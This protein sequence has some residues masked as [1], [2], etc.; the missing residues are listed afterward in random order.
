MST[1]DYYETLR[2][3][4]T[5]SQED[6]AEAYRRLS[7][8]HHPKNNSIANEAT[9]EYTFNQLAEAYEV[10]SDPNKK[11][12]YDIYGKDGLYNGIVDKNNN[13]KG[14]YKYAGNAHQIFEA[15]MGTSNPFALLRDCDKMNDECG[16][17]F[18]SAYGGQYQHKTSSTTLEPVVVELQCSLRELYNGAVKEIEYTKTV[19]NGDGHITSAKTCTVKVE[20][21]PGYGKESVI[22]FKEMGNE[23]PGKRSSDLI[24]KIVEMKDEVFKRVNTNDL[25]YIKRISLADAL[26]SVPVKINT[27]DNR[28]LAI[29]MDEIIT[30][31][32]VKVVKG[33]G[34]PVYTKEVDVND[35][36]QKKG[37]LYIKFDIAFPEYI[38]PEKKEEIVK[39]LESEESN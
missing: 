13:L 31:Q 33:E 30:P 2:L 5:C 15:F 38:E 14:A 22:E 32:T 26:R 1:F 11:S 21:F 36:K 24:V 35:M 23:A 37:D 18:S 6:I 8:Q 20:V 16:S 34:M 12:I 19:L 7:L 17:A 25:V 9:A 29:C 10:L 39:L 3:P 4:R 28:I 27:L